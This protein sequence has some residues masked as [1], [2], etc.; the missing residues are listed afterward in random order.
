MSEVTLKP[1]PFCGGEAGGP[2]DCYTGM[3]PNI[4]AWMVYCETNNCVLESC[5]DYATPEEAITAWNTRTQ[6]DTPDAVV[7]AALKR[8]KQQL[9]AHLLDHMNAEAAH[10]EVDYIETAI[11]QLKEVSRGK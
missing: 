1:C 7:E 9:V 3:R 11:R 6:A 10:K 8:A 2:S 5:R 4:E